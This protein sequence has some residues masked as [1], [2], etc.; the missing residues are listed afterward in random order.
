MNSKPSPI[1]ATDSG[2]SDPSSHGWL[3]CDRWL[4]LAAAGEAVTGFALVLFPPL[5]VRLLL[6]AEIAGAGIVVSRITG[7]SLIALGFACWPGGGRA[8]PLGAMSSYSL[9]ATLYLAYLGI[10][11]EWSGPL[12]WPAVALHAALTIFL[13]QAWLDRR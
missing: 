2:F 10:G 7:I 12:L 4:A 9:F 8:R 13:A 5:V 3:S 6:G 11:G 1:R